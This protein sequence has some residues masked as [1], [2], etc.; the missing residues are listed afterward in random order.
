MLAELL[1]LTGISSASENSVL[2]KGGS[3]WNDSSLFV[4]SS[5]S[6][7]MLMLSASSGMLSGMA[8]RVGIILAGK[9]GYGSTSICRGCEILLSA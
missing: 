2:S 6:D 7:S 8:A 3:E 1:E 9:T 5:K 4:L